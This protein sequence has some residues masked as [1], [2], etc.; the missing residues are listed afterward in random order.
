MPSSATITAFYSFAANTRARAS[1]V[2]ANFDNMRGHVLPIEPL[3]ATSSNILY[4]IGSDEHRWRTGYFKT[5]DFDRNTSTSSAI[6][7]ADTATTTSEVVYKINGTEVGRMLATGFRTNKAAISGETTAAA[8]NGLAKAFVSTTNGVTTWTAA[9]AQITTR[10][11]PVLY[12]ISGLQ[13]A[14]TTPGTT[15]ALTM[16]GAYIEVDVYRDTTTSVVYSARH[17]TA[18]TLWNTGVFLSTSTGY[19][20]Y[21]NIGFTDIDPS[22]TAGAHSYYVRITK[23]ATNLTFAGLT[24]GKLFAIEL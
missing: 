4:D 13:L 5:L 20:Q 18:D 23:L 16:T 6:I 8:Q 11:G 21:L 12:G 3:T 24:A 10:G 17:G 1:Q 15:G 9:A 2:Q 14:M 19:S 7:E 22:C